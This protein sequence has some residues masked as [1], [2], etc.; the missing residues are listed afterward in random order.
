[1]KPSVSLCLGIVGLSTLS[2]AQDEGGLKKK[3]H[4]APA[5]VSSGPVTKSEAV[6]TFQ[7]LA[8]LMK[9]IIHIPVKAS[10]IIGKPTEPVTKTEIITELM[11]FYKVAEPSFTNTPRRIHVELGRVVSKS[12]AQKKQLV[13]LIG[14]GF[15]GN[16]S[17]LATGTASTVAPNEF[18]DSIGFFLTQICECT[19]TSSTKWTPYLR[20]GN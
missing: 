3:V 18:G 15:V 14:K 12:A 7:K 1:M 17:V 9:A 13:F 5:V 10:P 6:A 19:N 2:L 8:G 16:Y 20:S 11:R 4:R